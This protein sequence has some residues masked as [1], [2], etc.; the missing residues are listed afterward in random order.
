MC[1]VHVP[2]GSAAPPGYLD[3]SVL[4]RRVI[5][6]A[7]SRQPAGVTPP[8]AEG[9]VGAY[10]TAVEK[11]AAAE[12][13]VFRSPS[14]SKEESELALRPQERESALRPAAERR[15]LGKAVGVLLHRWLE[16]WNGN[17]EEDVRDTFRALW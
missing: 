13:P 11:M 5:P 1:I 3:G 15:D 6:E 8:S 7:P 9:A 14:G 17:D 2:E 12:A 4:H 10:E 16:R